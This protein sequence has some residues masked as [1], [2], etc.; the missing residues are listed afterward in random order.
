MCMLCGCDYLEP[1]K[2]IGAKT[3]FKLVKE[4]DSMEEILD[5]LRKGKHAPPEDWPYEE[6][7]ELFRKPNVIPS[8]E[9]KVC[10][11]SPLPLTLM[12]PMSAY[13][14]TLARVEGSRR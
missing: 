10:P 4:H 3:A 9:V 11:P 5:H 6:A 14:A 8:E 1:I 12:Q 7:R 2:G 13:L